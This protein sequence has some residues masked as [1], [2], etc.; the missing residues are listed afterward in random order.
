L[1]IGE[2]NYPVDFDEMMVTSKFF[3]EYAELSDAIV[4]LNEYIGTTLEMPLYDFTI[5]EGIYNVDEYLDLLYENEDGVIG[6]F[7]ENETVQKEVRYLELNIP[8]YC[9]N[10]D[11]LES[12]YQSHCQTLIKDNKVSRYFAT[13]DEFILY[14][15]DFRA[16]VE[17]IEP[18]YFDILLRSNAVYYVID[19]NDAFLEDGEPKYI[20]RVY[21]AVHEEASSF[22]GVT[23]FRQFVSKSQTTT[24]TMIVTAI[25]ENDNESIV[26]MDQQTYNRL[27]ISGAGVTNIDGYYSIN[28]ES[29]INEDNTP[30]II[31]LEAFA[32]PLRLFGRSNN[33]LDDFKVIRKENIEAGETCAVFTVDNVLNQNTTFIDVPITGDVFTIT[34]YSGCKVQSESFHYLN[35]IRILFGVFF[36]TLMFISIIFFNILLSVILSERI[37][38]IGIY[39]SVGSTSKDIKMLFFIEIFVEVAI[40]ALLSIGMIYYA[41]VIINSVFIEVI[42]QGTGVINFAGMKLSIGTDRVITSIS[43]FNLAFYIVVVSVLLGFLSN[44]NVSKLANTKPIDIIREV[45]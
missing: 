43:F 21:R 39:R 16:Q 29:G 26:Y 1:F 22:Q 23:E 14:M 33:Y 25:L 41:N 24:K 34:D 7:D 44:R 13:I 40:A 8:Y 11:D 30:E 36:N 3:R 38:E 35:S 12:Y 2:S 45:E 5:S 19:E 18:G 17:L 6:E 31:A 27:F 4:N 15:D 20:E 10:Y 32:E 37:S 28:L 9:Y 42:N